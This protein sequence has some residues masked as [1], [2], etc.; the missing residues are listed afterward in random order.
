MAWGRREEE[1]GNE[2]KTRRGEKKRKGAGW[3]RG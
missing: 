3:G 1:A 2:R